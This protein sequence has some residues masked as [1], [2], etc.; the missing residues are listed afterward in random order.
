MKKELTCRQR[1]ILDFVFS[2]TQERRYQP[3]IREIGKHF[4]IKSTRGVWDHL[5]ALSQKGYL[6]RT[7]SK[8]RSIE[9]TDL[10]LGEG[11]VPVPLV[12]RISAGQPL[13]AMENIED[14]FHLDKSLVRGDNCFLLKVEGNSMTGAGILE[15]DLLLVREQPRAENGEIVVALME[16]EATVK[17]FYKQKDSIRLQP[18]NPDYKPISVKKDDPNFRIVGKVIG[19]IRKI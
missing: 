16:D 17:R 11:I 7:K 8:S 9:L 12:G 4:G 6:K 14:T 10:K 15:N 2:F 19:L 5:I 1:E 18:E 13:L 3:S